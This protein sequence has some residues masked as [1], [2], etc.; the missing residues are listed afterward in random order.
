MAAASSATSMIWTM[1]TPCGHWLSGT[2]VG[3]V[4]VAQP[5]GHR[6][7]RPS[8][9]LPLLPL[10]SARCICEDVGGQGKGELVGAKEWDDRLMA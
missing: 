5:R 8:R 3:S 7:P 1:T 2:P 4:H 9:A 6:K 10:A